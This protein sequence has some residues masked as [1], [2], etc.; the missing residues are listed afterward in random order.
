[1]NTPEIPNAGLQPVPVGVHD[2]AQVRLQ[3]IEQHLAS[4]DTNLIS[5]RLPGNDGDK[6]DHEK[7]KNNEEADAVVRKHLSSLMKWDTLKD[8]EKKEIKKDLKKALS[9]AES[10]DIS[11][12][13]SEF[14]FGKVNPSETGISGMIIVQSASDPLH[15][16]LKTSLYPAR[17]GQGVDTT[18]TV[19]SRNAH[20]AQRLFTEALGLKQKDQI[21]ASQGVRQADTTS[22][23][24]EYVYLKNEK[25]ERIPLGTVEVDEKTH[26]VSKAIRDEDGIRKMEAVEKAEA[27]K[28]ALEYATILKEKGYLVSKAD[29]QAFSEILKKELNL[30][31]D[32]RFKNRVLHC[33]SGED[34]GTFIMSV[35]DKETGIFFAVIEFDF[36]KKQFAN[37]EVNK[38]KFA[39]IFADE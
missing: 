4:R 16:Y 8:D 10:D 18:T 24:M 11:V 3:D 22:Y 13:F 34:K 29:R 23:N 28:T 12:H 19:D 15:V 39:E 5:A 6:K 30:A 1:M 25:Y 7:D 33:I 27:P 31:D 37:P 17:G 21:S 9:I 38:D 32:K 14:V 20:G 2:L 36:Q 26:K 35:Q